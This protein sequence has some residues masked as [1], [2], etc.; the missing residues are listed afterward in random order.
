M[1]LATPSDGWERSG[2]GQTQARPKVNMQNTAKYDL[3]Q[4]VNEKF[5]NIQN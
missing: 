1:S 3:L 2:S 5:F 4:D